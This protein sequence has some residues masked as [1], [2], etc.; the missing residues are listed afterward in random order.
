MTATYAFDT[1]AIIAFLYEEPGHRRVADRLSDVFDGDSEG[2]MAATNVAEVFYLVARFEG[3]G[4]EPTTASLR[5][6][7]RDVRA[8]ERRGLTIRRPN[9]RAVGEIKAEGHISIADA[10]AVALAHER[11]ATLLVGGDDDFDDLPVEVTV[12]RFRDDG[13]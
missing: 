10:C 5:T 1:E 12:E 9:W 7:D 8:L 6:A 11:E 3:D 13:V 4:D 2:T